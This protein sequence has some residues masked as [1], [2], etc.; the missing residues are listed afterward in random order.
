MSL[1]IQIVDFP[2]K[3]ITYFDSLHVD[4]KQCLSAIQYAILLLYKA[5]SKLETELSI[6]R[7]CCNEFCVSV[8]WIKFKHS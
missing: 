8:K 5:I 1:Y 3:C 7:I 2:E 4:N 6:C